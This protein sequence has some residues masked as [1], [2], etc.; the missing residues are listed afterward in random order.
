MALRD[1]GIVPYIA[2]E[3][4]AGIV[5]SGLQMQIQSGEEPISQERFPKSLFVILSISIEDGA[6][7][8]EKY[9]FMMKWLSQHA[10]EKRAGK[11]WTREDARVGHAIKRLQA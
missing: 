4:K 11:H 1:L 7:P 9:E 5:Y 3:Y 2:T 10:K 6:G 8:L